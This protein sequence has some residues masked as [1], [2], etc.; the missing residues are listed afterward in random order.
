MLFVPSVGP[1]YDDSRIRPW[2]RANTKH[3]DGGKYYEGM[4]RAALAVSPDM[5]T[6]TSYNEW[7]EGTQIEP[8]TSHTTAA[9]DAYADYSPHAPDHYL[10]LTRR[11]ADEAASVCSRTRTT[12]E[13]KAA[14]EL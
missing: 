5:V 8:A 2:N 14:D 4:W 12:S 1:G 10:A 7:G 3:R 13:S 11:W 6:I 9:G